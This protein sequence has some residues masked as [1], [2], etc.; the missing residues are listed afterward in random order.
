MIPKDATS[1]RS[2]RTAS[3]ESR[4]LKRISRVTKSCDPDVP[5]RSTVVPPCVAFA[6]G[7]MRQAWPDRTAAKPLTRNTD[8]NSAQTSSRL[9]GSDEMTVTLPL[10]AGSSTSVRPVISETCSAKTLISVSRRL[11][12]NVESLVWANPGARFTASVAKSTKTLKN[13]RKEIPNTCSSRPFGL[14]QRE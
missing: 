3:F 14:R 10:T 13:T 12:T 5:V 4:F 11:M 2:T 7:T 9:R 8:W 6:C 1:G